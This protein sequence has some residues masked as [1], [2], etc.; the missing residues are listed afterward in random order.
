MRRTLLKYPKLVTA[1]YAFQNLRNRTFKEVGAEWGFNST[2]IANGMALADLDNDGDLD[3]VINCMNSEALLYRNEANA[4]RVAVRL[5]GNGANTQ[6]IGARV[7]V[8]GGPVTQS[9][10]I[11]AGGRYVS[12]DQAER[13]FAAGAASNL[14]LEVDWPSGA[15]S[16]IK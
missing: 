16:E 10:V 1:N 14:S 4:P 7:T 2:S 6:G 3:V 12:S 8:N 9:Q 15:R 5:K 11:M 13:V